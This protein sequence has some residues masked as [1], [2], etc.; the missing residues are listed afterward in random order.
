MELGKND[1]QRKLFVRKRKRAQQFIFAANIERHLE[2]LCAAVSQDGTGGLING[3]SDKTLRS[4]GNE[5][6][7]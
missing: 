3:H 4:K 1:K 2:N 7:I 6:K 5:H